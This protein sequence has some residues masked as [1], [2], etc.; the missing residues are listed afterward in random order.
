MNVEQLASRAHTVSGIYIATMILIVIHTPVVPVVWPEVFEV[1]DVSTFCVK[2]F[3]EY[4]LLSHVQC[5][6]FEEVIYTVFKLH[7]VFTSFFRGIDQR[8]D[9][10]HGHCRRNFDG[11][12]LAVFHGV[13]SH[14]C[15]MF[16]VSRDVNEVDIVTFAKFF[17]GIFATGVR[18]CFRQAC[19]GQDFLCTGG[20]KVAKGYD[21]CSG[22]V[23]E[24]F[25]CTRS[26]HTQANES[27]TY[28]V[29]FRSSQSDYVFLSGGTYRHWSLDRLDGLCYC[30]RGASKQCKSDKQG[31]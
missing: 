8:P 25:Y 27:D 16:P 22:D 13:D 10:V 12:V 31:I 2:H 15:V 23:S 18:S 14:L 6:Q 17:P 30:T 9:F 4:A 3:T 19:L 26:T 28:H 1:V 21:L 11:N 7:T 29:E 24:A 20:D 5:S